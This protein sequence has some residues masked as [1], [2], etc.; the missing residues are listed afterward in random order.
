MVKC[1]PGSGS[2]M[3]DNDCGAHLLVE[4]VSLETQHGVSVKCKFGVLAA[5]DP[6]QVGKSITEFFPVEG[7]AVDKFYNLCEAAGLITA[8]QRKAA[9]DQGVG[10]DVDETLL[11]G[12]Q[13][14]GQ[15]RM[16]ENKRKNL[17]TGQY[18]TDPDNPGPFPRLGFRTFGVWDKK[19]EAIPK[20][21]QFLAAIP[22]P[23]AASGGNGTQR[24]TAPQQPTPTQAQHPAAPVQ[25]PQQAAAPP[26]VAPAMNW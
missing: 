2:R 15:I 9:A 22:R 25:Q 4:D 16:E 21:P 3:I 26:T 20:D 8:Q 19:A 17:S 6:G 10:I 11:K 7:K 12:R 18:E 13:L 14:C 23:A 1:D 24:P 5:T